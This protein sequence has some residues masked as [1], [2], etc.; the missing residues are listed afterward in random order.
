MPET[1]DGSWIGNYAR[2]QGKK[3]V[4]LTWGGGLNETA[5]LDG[6]CLRLARA[7]A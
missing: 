5:V 1:F 7:C 3:N 6:G 2:E 4:R